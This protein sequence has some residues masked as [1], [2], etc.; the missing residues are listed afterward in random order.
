ME[1][2]YRYI[3]DTSLMAYTSIREDGSVGAMQEKVLNFIKYNPD[4]TDSEITYRLGYSDRN[5]IRPRRN[6]LMK[7]GV[8]V[9]SGKKKCSISKRM[10][11]TWRAR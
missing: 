4:L 2:D 3:K 6:E 1:T 11:Y 9:P 8:V 10:A 7:K 5:K